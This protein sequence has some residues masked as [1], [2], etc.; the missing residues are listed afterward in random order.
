MRSRAR[1]TRRLVTAGAI[2]AVAVVTA[3]L[4][5]G[6]SATSASSSGAA[7]DAHKCLVMTGSGDAAFT[8][9]FNPYTGPT[10][11][12][13]I[14][15]GA[16]YEPLLVAT[17]AGGGHLYPWLAS[18]WKW[19][20]ANKTL[21][22]QIVKNAKW[23]DGQP[24]TPD[25]VV[26]SLT[27]G[28]QDKVMDIIG[29]TREGTNIVSVKRSGANGVA[30]NLK[31]PD[32]QFIAAQLNLQFV[33]PKHVW[34]KVKKVATFTN[35]KPV[36]SG[37]FNQIGRLTN[38]DIVF[39]KNPDYWLSGA[40]KLPCLE[41][42][43]TASNDAALLAI[44]SGK[45]DW[46][47]NFVPNVESAYEAKDPA[48]YHAFYSTT[49]YPIS[50]TFDDTQYPFSL[51]ALRQAMS[52]AINRSDVSK[53]GEYGYAPPT[54]AIGL[55]G[56]FPQWVTDPNIKAQAQAMAT[57]NPDAARKLLTDNGF[58]YSGSKLI[59]PKGNPVAFDIHVISGWSDWVASL[60]II[61]K[62]LQAVGID[63][64]TKLE[65]TYD[66]WSSAAFSTK[67]PTL[68]WQNASQ[69]SPYGFFFANLSQNAMIAPGEDGTSTGNWEHFADASATGLLNQWKTSLNPDV[70]HKLA[71]KLQAAWL[72]TMP[73]IP[74]FI[75]PRWSTYSTKYFHGF[76]S[77]KNAYA[78]PIFTQFPDNVVSFTRIAPG[79]K[80]GA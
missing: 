18:S 28:K 2:A 62:N 67:T 65:P 38:Q 52:L 10:L 54:D 7:A 72:R 27:A 48:H 29:L 21:T 5:P 35:P 8:H 17:V 41:Y 1:T 60:Q 20:N 44:Q 12:G 73:V 23:S 19:S 22:L 49:A 43:E 30:I 71:T 79:G 6:A 32:S 59:D 69:G 46:T 39:N 57:Y 37:P 80:A 61:T 31:T 16:I 15:K 34:S 42:Q 56:I 63:A 25:D 11:N 47:H 75:G 33:V 68:L 76:T 13:N 3:S 24:L 36:G 40:P 45:V 78:D 9:A 58:T 50:L 53:L 4:V 77:E 14:M 51:V 74:L 64:N 26:Y 55:N 66:S 70:Q